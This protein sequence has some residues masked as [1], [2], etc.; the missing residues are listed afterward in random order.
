MNLLSIVRNF[1]RLDYE[2]TFD[3]PKTYTKPFTIKIPRELMPD[4]DIFESYI[5]N[6]KDWAHICKH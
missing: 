5:E 4:S 3:D 6:E 2:V 1:G